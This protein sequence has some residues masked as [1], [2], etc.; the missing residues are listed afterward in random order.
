MAFLGGMFS[1]FCASRIGYQVQ[2]LFD[3]E[4]HWHDCAYDVPLEEEEVLDVPP[5]LQAAFWGQEGQPGDTE[6]K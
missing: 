2:N 4:E 6:E 1:G 3:D 5:A